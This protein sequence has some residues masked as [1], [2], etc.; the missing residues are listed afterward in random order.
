MKPLSRLSSLLI[1]NLIVEVEPEGPFD[2]GGGA[3]EAKSQLAE[4]AT[5][6]YKNILIVPNADTD[7]ILEFE[8]RLN[9]ELT[10]PF[11][12]RRCRRSRISSMGTEPHH[13]EDCD[14]QHDAGLVGEVD[15][16][17]PL[18]AS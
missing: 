10:A 4:F 2:G 7:M 8:E 3:V 12:S 1:S 11:T 18:S 14:G 13:L 9:N 17:G 16:A 5:R 15:L 6:G